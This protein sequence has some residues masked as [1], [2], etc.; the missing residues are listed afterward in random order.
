[1][2]GQSGRTQPEES[3]SGSLSV[4]M[5]MRHPGFTIYLRAVTL[6]LGVLEANM[7]LL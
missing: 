7:R 5:I 4:Q 3:N 1:M 6:E 2:L